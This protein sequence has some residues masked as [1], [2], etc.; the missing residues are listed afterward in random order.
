[1]DKDS[2]Y[3]SYDPNDVRKN[4]NNFLTKR[5]MLLLYFKHFF[6]DESY[7]FN[8]LE[9]NSQAIMQ[10]IQENEKL[11]RRINSWA[12]LGYSVGDLLAVPNIAEFARALNALVAEFEHD[13]NESTS[14]K[15]KQLLKKNKKDSNNSSQN[16][17]NITFNEM[18]NTPFDFDFLE[19]FFALCDVMTEAY[20]KMM[21]VDDRFLT[22]GYLD[23]VTK[24]DTNIKK[25]MSSIIKEVDYSV[26]LILAQEFNIMMRCIVEE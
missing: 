16:S 20:K 2:I 21:Q 24:I 11:R 7:Y 15:M 5:T 1:M 18:P 25:I 9:F 4:L 23:I 14:Q 26:R 12:Q 22:K 6:E 17:T 8:T 10:N 3:G 19:T 13:K